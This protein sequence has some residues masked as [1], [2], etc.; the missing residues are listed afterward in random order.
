MRHFVRLVRNVEAARLFD[1][2]LV[3]AIATVLITRLYLQLTG[4]PQISSSTLHIAHLAPGGVL[5]MVSILVMLGSINRSARDIA[6]VVGGIGFGLFWD[7][8][9]KFIT[10]DNDYFFQPAV[11]VIYLTFVV[12]YL[13]TRYVI[14]RSYHSHDYLANALDL[15]SEGAIGELDPREY[16]KAKSL[17]RKVDTD[18]P[19]Y[20]AAQTLLQSTKPTKNYRPFLV[21]RLADAVYRPFQMLVKQPW[22]RALLI[23]FFYV[24][25]LS[26]LV[27]T[28]VV[29]F[30]GNTQPLKHLVLN[31]SADSNLVAAISSVVASA[32]V[33]WG[34]W[35]LRQGRAQRA[36]QKFEGALLVTI[37]VTQTFLFFRYQFTACVALVVN[38]L[39]L[40]SVR[41]L[42]SSQAERS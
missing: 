3:A 19:M 9:G 34:I 11:G 26:L 7:E 12:L 28:L 36:L 31:P 22:Y 15:I 2:F 20:A 38:L 5:M 21:D 17:L 40:F 8:V 29:V 13:I 23:R 35:L 25:G 16:A 30:T 41:M 6:A 27:T 4:Y 24:Y 18:H 42:I 10:K 37:L 39:L 32:L 14:R 33:L 1:S